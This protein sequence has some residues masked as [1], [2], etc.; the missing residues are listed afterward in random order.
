[1]AKKVL[2]SQEKFKAAIGKIL[3]QGCNQSVGK[4]Q[5]TEIVNQW[6]KEETP[7]SIKKAIERILVEVT[8]P[9][10]GKWIRKRYTCIP[11]YYWLESSSK[12]GDTVL[13]WYN[14]E[15]VQAE[16]FPLKLHWQN[17]EDERYSEVLDWGYEERGFAPAEKLPVE[18]TFFGCE[19]NIPV[20]S[21]HLSLHLSLCKHGYASACKI[22]WE[23]RCNQ[24]DPLENGLYVMRSIIPHGFWKAWEWWPDCWQYYYDKRLRHEPPN[25]PYAA[26][27]GGANKHD[28][29]IFFLDS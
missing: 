16:P 3:S 9:E 4:A 22:Q 7:D 29:E 23:R 27:L 5:L 8:I 21:L 28:V 25:D 2:S 26:V 6:E 20:E 24:R 11:G 17:H 13:G 10:W 14:Q 12:F 1:M 15:Q 19:V 18:Y